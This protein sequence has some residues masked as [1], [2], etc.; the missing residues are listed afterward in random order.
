MNYKGKEDVT[1][2]VIR[3]IEKKNENIQKNEIQK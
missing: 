3:I 1:K 2:N